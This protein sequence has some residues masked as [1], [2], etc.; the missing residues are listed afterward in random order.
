MLA[1]IDNGRIS[2]EFSTGHGCILLL[3]PLYIAIPS[4]YCKVIDV[5]NT[6]FSRGY[7]SQVVIVK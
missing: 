6:V 3:P 7:S 4:C 1:I 2:I 5:W